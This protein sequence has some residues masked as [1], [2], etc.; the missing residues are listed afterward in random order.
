[1]VLF[2]EIDHFLLDRDSERY[3]KQDTVFQFMTPGMLTKLNELRR[4]KQALFIVATNYEDR[5]DAAIKRT[6]WIDQKYIVLPPDKARRRSL[7]EE[8]LRKLKKKMDN[9]AAKNEDK[10]YIFEEVL[11]EEDWRELQEKSLFLGFKDLQAVVNSIKYGK[12]TRVDLTNQLGD[13]LKFRARTTSLEAYRSRFVGKNNEVFNIRETPMEEFLCL[14]ALF[15]EVSKPEE[16]KW[17]T[18]MPFVVKI[19]NENL[20]SGKINTVLIKTYA[21][22]L[23][24]NSA[25]KVAQALSA[26]A[27]A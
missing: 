11:F 17:N 27:P 20:Q 10:E 4:T 1:M 3:S 23:D 9:L 18:T 14:T 25:E 16:L 13:Q 12:L 26:I 2:D 19:L 15:L 8:F 5:I 24:N 22:E 7:L 6:G 21:T